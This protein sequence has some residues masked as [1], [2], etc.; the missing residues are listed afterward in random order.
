MDYNNLNNNQNPY[1]QQNGSRYYSA[2]PTNFRDPGMTF[3]TIS[4][5]FGLGSLFTV[6]TV[7]LPFILGGLAIVF[8][9]LSKG[10]NKKMNFAAKIGVGTAITGLALLATIIGT[11]V[12]IFLSSSRETLI[13]F[14]EQMDKQIEHQTGYTPEQLIGESYEDIMKDYADLLGK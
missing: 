10:Y 4:V 6:F 11:L 13:Q 12:G 2:P 14:G 8:A 3:A 7:Y 1:N 9:I 5:I